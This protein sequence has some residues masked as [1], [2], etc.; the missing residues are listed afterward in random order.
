MPAAKISLT[1]HTC[2]EACWHAIEEVCHCS[3]GGRNHGIL[4]G[5]GERPKRTCKIQGTWYELHAIGPMPEIKRECHAL[6][7][8]AQDG[9]YDSFYQKVMVYYD[10]KPGDLYHCKS[11]SGNQLKWAEVRDMQLPF[12]YILWKRIENPL[13]AAAQHVA[14]VSERLFA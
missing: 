4:R 1:G 9:E 2:G 6:R 8:E 3:C 14:A 5:G 11:A 12:P 10:S 7:K 13:A